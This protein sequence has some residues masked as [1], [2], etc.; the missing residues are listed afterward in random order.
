[1]KLYQFYILLAIYV[2][3]YLVCDAIFPKFAVRHE[4]PAAHWARGE[5]Y[6]PG[7]IELTNQIKELKR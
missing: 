6:P 5:G 2:I 4:A 1:M 7:S 3:S